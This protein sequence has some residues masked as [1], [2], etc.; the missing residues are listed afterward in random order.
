VAELP[1]PFIDLTAVGA[2]FVP[3]GDRRPEQRA[4]AEL[5][6]TLTDELLATLRDRIA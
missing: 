5:A 3:V 2:R 6:E 4:A 1:V